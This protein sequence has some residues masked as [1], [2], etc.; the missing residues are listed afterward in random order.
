MLE[1]KHLFNSGILVLTQRAAEAVITRSAAPILNCSTRRGRVSSVGVR[2]NWGWSRE[3]GWW[4]RAAAL[5]TNLAARQMPSAVQWNMDSMPSLFWIWKTDAKAL[6]CRN[7][8]RSKFL[9]LS[10]R[11]FWWLTLLW[12]GLEPIEQVLGHTCV[13]RELRFPAAPLA[14]YVLPK[15]S[16]AWFTFTATSHSERETKQLLCSPWA[17]GH[18]LRQAGLAFIFIFFY[19][20][21]LNTQRKVLLQDIRL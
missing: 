7:E 11:R 21:R 1:I 12:H 18:R 13:H 10:E 16:C 4:W 15:A 17:T 14:F 3:Q 5:H 20:Q 9:F 8:T 2:L 19:K 6:S